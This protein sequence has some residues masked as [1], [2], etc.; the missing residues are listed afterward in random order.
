MN[1]VYKISAIILI[2]LVVSAPSC[3]DE[4]EI[5]ML[6]EVSMNAEKDEIRMEFEKEY[7]TETELYAFEITAKQKLSDFADYFNIMTDTSLDLSFRGKAGEMIK[8]TFQSDNSN[9]ELFGLDKDQV[10]GLEVGVLIKKG[11]KNKLPHLNFSF[12]S[13]VINKPL[14]RIN[15]TTYSGILSFSQNFSNPSTPEQTIK[16][17]KRNIDF[18]VVKENK[19]FGTDSL[20]IWNVRLGEIR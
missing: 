5:A 20:N 9:L 11:M 10:K 8:N 6:E 19:L 4:K 17:I 1:T 16:S 18:Y 3:V 12:D 2:V 7:L 15:N 14:H 13:M